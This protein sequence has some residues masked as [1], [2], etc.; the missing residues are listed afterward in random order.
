MYDVLQDVSKVGKSKVM[1]RKSYR[2]L[3]S[4][5]KKKNCNNS[6]KHYVFSN[7]LNSDVISYNR[8]IRGLSNDK[9]L[10]KKFISFICPHKDE[11]LNYEVIMCD[12]IEE[13]GMLKLISYIIY[14]KRNEINEFISLKKK[15]ED[16][17]YRENYVAAREVLD[18]IDKNICFSMWSCSQR[19]ILEEQINGLESNKQL[20][21]DY[22]N[23]SKNSTIISAILDFMSTLAEKNT[24]YYTFQD[25]ITKLLNIIDKKPILYDYFSYKF[26]LEYDFSYKSFSSAMQIEFQFSIIDLYET[27]V[28][29]MIFDS[30]NDRKYCSFVEMF[31]KEIH[32]NRLKNVMILFNYSTEMIDFDNNYDYYNIFDLYTKGDYSK[33]IEL[34][35]VYHN[36]YYYD[37]QLIILYVKSHI[38]LNRQLEEDSLLI[39]SI[40]NLYSLNEQYD[41]ALNTLNAFYKQYCFVDWG[42]K[43]RALVKRKSSFDDN[44]IIE[45]SY[46]YD[47]IISP[48]FVKHLPNEN[49][50]KLFIGDLK[51]V[52]SC[53]AKLFECYIN[54]E[55]IKS[56]EIDQKRQFIYN[57]I[58]KNKKGDFKEA[59]EYLERQFDIMFGKDTYYSE[60]I[61][62]LLFMNYLSENNIAK[63]VSLCVKVYMEN[64][65]FIKRFPINK[66]VKLL[67]N[68]NNRNVYGLIE[69]PIFIYIAQKRDNNEI[70]LA[71]ENY[72]E[73]NK[74]D[75]I[76]EV[77]TKN[78]INKK[79]LNFFLASICTLDVLK[80][81]VNIYISGRDYTDIRI[82]ILSYLIGS[83][84]SQKKKY[85]NEIAEIMKKIEIDN[86]AE[87]INKSRI[88]VDVD[89]IYVEIKQWLVEYFDMYINVKN[90]ASS[91]VGIDVNSDSFIEDLSRVANE[92]NERMKKE[93]LLSQ[94]YILVSNMISR[95]A[96]EF[97]FNPIFGLESFLS[98]RIRHGY[99][100]DQLITVFIEHG[101]IS[102][103]TN[104]N[105]G[106]YMI[107]E[108]LSSIIKKDELEFFLPAFSDFTDKIEKKINEINTNWIRIKYH[109]G[110]VGLFDFTNFVSNTKLISLDNITDYRMFYN[111][112]IEVLWSYVKESLEKIKGL[113]ESDLKKYFD[114]ALFSLEKDIEKFEAEYPTIVS[115]IKHKINLCKSILPNTINEFKDVFQVQGNKCKDFTLNDLVST[116]KQI[117]KRLFAKYDEITFVDMIDFSDY[118]DG[119]Y[120][121]YLVDIICILINN[122]INH[123]GYDAEKLKIEIEMFKLPETVK[124]EVIDSCKAQYSEVEKIEDDLLCISVKN[125]LNNVDVKEKQKDVESIFNNLYN[126]EVIKKYA[127]KEGGSGVYKIYQRLKYN[128]HSPYIITFDINEEEFEFNIFLGLSKLLSGRELI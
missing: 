110:D 50:K 119:M 2:N 18:Y 87:Q 80:K 95:I 94:E 14:N 51:K 120:F 22:L 29:F 72:L 103:T 43:I 108:Y 60:R 1:N 85:E 90:F 71:Y 31:S 63:C 39:N 75:D 118:L 83:D 25:K 10:N 21:Y 64:N 44:G 26:D 41:D 99:L 84:C 36:K 5:I 12:K 58:I 54:N 23:V 112:V 104:D 57:V 33:T 109:K 69:Y 91:V 4:F 61:A 107:N 124:K 46:L 55:E 98:S 73:E 115:Q 19:F 53:S 66:A 127:Q 40:F 65:N 79:Y 67:N 35:D 7:I 30:I 37:F 125:N 93:P 34:I 97:L 47:A 116:C 3:I 88:Y 128:M 113:I 92:L 11:L 89:K 68:D 123:S 15:Y 48:N 106:K 9:I 121:P 42:K 8:I 49:I 20:L 38:Y 126:P 62:R 17:L 96:E 76:L 28:F 74:I 59:T 117:N 45:A 70:K 101:L 27:Y 24:S 6:L 105:S 16:F 78:K 77:T 102:K 82:Q 52:C 111:S 32:D 100:K 13:E 122:A 56:N 114:E 86:R 81:D